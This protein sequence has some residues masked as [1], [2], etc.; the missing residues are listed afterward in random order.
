MFGYTILLPSSLCVAH[1]TQ[2]SAQCHL[3]ADSLTQ[4]VVLLLDR[5]ASPIRRQ[6]PLTLR[7]VACVWT[8]GIRLSIGIAIG[9][10]ME[11]RYDEE[12]TTGTFSLFRRTCCHVT[13]G[14]VYIV[15][16]KIC[17]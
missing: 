14:Q 5:I 4:C 15:G 2:I 12:D 6:W 7:S 9:K 3:A 8:S 10:A 1:P 13:M 11:S 17:W 16:T